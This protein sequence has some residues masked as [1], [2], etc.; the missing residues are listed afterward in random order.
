MFP[1]LSMAIIA[2]NYGPDASPDQG[3]ASQMKKPTGRLRR[4]MH[5]KKRAKKL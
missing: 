2:V 3:L 1:K 4:K 5:L